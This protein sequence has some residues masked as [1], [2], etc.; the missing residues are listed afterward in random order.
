M[1]DDECAHQRTLTLCR[2]ALDML[3]PDGDMAIFSDLHVSAL[4]QAVKVFAATGK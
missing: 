1:T 3:A 4:R 2:E